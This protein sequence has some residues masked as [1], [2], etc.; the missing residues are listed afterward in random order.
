[1]RIRNFR[2]KYESKKTELRKSKILLGIKFPYYLT[3]FF[4]SS[5][6]AATSL[7]KL[8]F[9]PNLVLKS[10]SIYLRDF[11]VAFLKYGFQFC[12]FYWFQFCS[13]LNW[14]KFWV[15][16]SKITKSSISLANFHFEFLEGT[17]FNYGLYFVHFVLNKVF[18]QVWVK[19]AKW[20]IRLENVP[21]GAC[22]THYGAPFFHFEYKND[23]CHIW[24]KSVLYR[25]SLLSSQPNKKQFHLVDLLVRRL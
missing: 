2:I 21:F 13:F 12:S 19:V 22:F 1:M 6:D 9:W 17:R 3:C 25:V 24:V 11:K 15:N 14:R 23:F 7:V 18:G 16:L 20:C 8:S 5:L 10:K 4:F